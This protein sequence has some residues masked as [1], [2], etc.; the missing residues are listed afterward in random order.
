MV[1][2]IEFGNN[3]HINS[4]YTGCMTYIVDCVRRADVRKMYERVKYLRR[5]LREKL[6]AKSQTEPWN[7][8][9]EQVGLFAYIELSGILQT[10]YLSRNKE[11]YKPNILLFNEIFYDISRL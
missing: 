2:R 6:E 7:N 8:I 10:K 4:S 11:H 9:T 5:C 1:G 3:R